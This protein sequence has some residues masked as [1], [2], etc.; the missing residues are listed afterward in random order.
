M[1]Q[2]FEDDAVDKL[3]NAGGAGAPITGEAESAHTNTVPKV[4]SDFPETWLWV[5]GSTSRSVR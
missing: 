2:R 4:R 3:E 1:Y 5:D